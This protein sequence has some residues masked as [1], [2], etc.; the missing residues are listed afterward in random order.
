MPLFTTAAA[1]AA[2]WGAA[3]AQPEPRPWGAFTLRSSPVASPRWE[4]TVRIGVVEGR[5]GRRW[6]AEKLERNDRPARPQWADS[7][8]CPALA[9]LP[10]SLAELRPIVARE[11]PMVEETPSGPILR[12]YADSPWYTIEAP[13]A[14][15]GD[16]PGQ[17]RLGASSGPLET[18]VKGAMVRLAPCWTDEPPKP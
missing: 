9:E 5:G 6:T 7:I 8:A 15:E 3:Q 4:V 11:V 2:L 1:I 13:A 18:W 14:Y 16:W 17:I 10:A 12:V